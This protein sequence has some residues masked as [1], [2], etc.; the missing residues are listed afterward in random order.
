MWRCSL[1]LGGKPRPIPGQRP[2]NFGVKRAQSMRNDNQIQ[3]GCEKAWNGLAV[4]D[5]LDWFQQNAIKGLWCT[6]VLRVVSQ[7]ADAV[8]AESYII[9]VVDMY[10]YVWNIYIYGSF[11]ALNRLNSVN[12]CIVQTLYLSVLPRVNI[13]YITVSQLLIVILSD[14]LL[15]HPTD[16]SRRVGI[17][18]KADACVQGRAI[19]TE[20]HPRFPHLPTL[21]RQVHIV[22]LIDTVMLPTLYGKQSLSLRCGKEHLK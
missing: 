22:I 6:S 5:R 9:G 10:M 15:F 14:R 13:T 3:T 20:V 16:M 4:A 21:S 12:L 18:C 2:K 19:T 8:C 11:G 7:N 1:F 17:V